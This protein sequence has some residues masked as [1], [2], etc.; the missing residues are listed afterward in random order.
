MEPAS[1]GRAVSEQGRE[2]LTE[3]GLRAGLVLGCVGFML[4]LVVSGP[5][6]GLATPFGQPGFGQGSR[7]VAIGALLA[8]AGVAFALTHGARGVAGLL[9]ALVGIAWLATVPAT[10]VDGSDP[11][12]G[13]GQALAPLIGPALLGLTV[14][15][16]SRG[17]TGRLTILAV[18]GLV[19]LAILVA[20][21]RLAAYDPFADPTC[22][23]CGHGAPPLLVATAEQRLLL[24]RAAAAL[25]I[26]CAAG[27]LWLMVDRRPARGKNRG[28]TLAIAAGVISLTLVIAAGAAMQL[29]SAAPGPPPEARAGVIELAGA[30]GAG[31]LVLGLVWQAVDVLRLRLRM[32]Q[33]ARDVASATELGRLDVRMARALDDR[34]V[35]V[36][37]WYEGEACWVST[38]GEPLGPAP[39]DAEQGQLT[40]ERE[41]RPIATIR[42]RR[43]IEPQAIR[44]ELTSSMLV[45]LDNER[46]Q[47]VAMANLRVLH[48]SRA[49]LVSVQEAQR[50]QVERDLHDGLQQRILAIV[51][52]LRLARVAA[53]RSGERARMRWL[54]H[55]EGL[56]LA[57][58]E[59]VR[60]LARGIY[61]AILGQAG[62]AAALSSLADEAPVPMS[63][64][65]GPMPRLPQPL[66][67][68][69][70]QAISD[71]L[72][73]A[74][75]SGAAEL[76]VTVERVADDVVV[77]IDHDG[78]RASVRVGLVDRVAAAGGSLVD[79]ASASHAGTRLR[80]ALPC[81]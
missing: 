67:A 23:S 77:V 54:G 66:E 30:I 44:K 41:G 35:V 4:T 1:E 51:F 52:D 14:A 80:I 53:E 9:A 42:H 74:V 50:Q 28:G 34:S 5:S 72:A 55:A 69:I 79:E 58:V 47:A 13:P 59:E 71:A 46:L 11:L 10:S 31:L 62:L 76:A 7:D 48:A 27:V 75:R 15:I 37:Y 18:A 57:I 38:S 32:R 73:D 21:L 63:V 61:P 39:A 25:A 65:V 49:R 6:G 40:I 60:T 33:L 19:A 3:T 16:A 24:N 2:S 81:A 36:G 64:S 17:S 12:R 70:Y 45:A 68:T 8:A 43:D 26:A 22:V 78:S 29:S 20:A 56:A